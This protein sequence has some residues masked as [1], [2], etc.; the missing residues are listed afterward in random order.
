MPWKAGWLFRQQEQVPPDL[1]ALGLWPQQ[2]P[3][4][5]ACHRSLNNHLDGLAL[6]LAITKTS[7]RVLVAGKVPTGYQI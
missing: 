6:V 1:R 2:P 4:G 3:S 5:S 7:S